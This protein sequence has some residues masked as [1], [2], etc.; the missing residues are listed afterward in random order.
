M[1]AY[2]YSDTKTVDRIYYGAYVLVFIR[3]WKT[4]LLNRQLSSKDFFITQ[5]SWD[6]IEI[7]FMML[8]K[9]CIEQ[10]AHNFHEFNSQKC[11]RFFRLLRSYTSTESTII[12]VSMKDFITRIC[13]IEYEEKVMRELQDVIVFPKAIRRSTVS[14]RERENINNEEIENAIQK[15]FEDAKKKAIML[16]MD[17]LEINM[18]TLIK[19]VKQNCV[20]QEDED[21]NEDNNFFEI[22][23]NSQL[24]FDDLN[25]NNVELHNFLMVNKGD[26]LVKMHKAK[27]VHMLQDD[28]VKISPDIRHRFIPKKTITIQEVTPNDNLVWKSEIISKGDA[29]IL[30]YDNSICTG[31]VFCFRIENQRYQYNS[32]YSY[33]HINL[34]ESNHPDLS[35][36]L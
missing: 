7:N 28:K 17:C 9:L 2:S 25:Q 27:I 21:D 14:R 3:I 8:L 36:N 19:P 30:T 23:E 20:A 10:N 33:D 12:N 15:G 32:T 5:N 26:H 16:G 1:R 22:E 34:Y 18:K 11:E 13:K 29:I 6:G 31:T 35:I 4:F 24:P